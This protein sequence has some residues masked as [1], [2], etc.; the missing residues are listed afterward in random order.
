MTW[1]HI[2]LEAEELKPGKK[3]TEKKLFTLRER[4]KLALFKEM[5]DIL[6]VLLSIFSYFYIITLAFLFFGQLWREYYTI[7]FFVMALSEPY[8]GAVAVYTILKEFRKKK[9]KLGSLHKGEIFVIL[10]GLMLVI[11]LT[12]T[13]FSDN[14]VLGEPLKIIITNG[15]AVSLIYIGSVIHKP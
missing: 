1:F 7:S 9:H 11:A 4:F 6:F 8:L 15:I 10:W 13:I 5:I 14:Y 3:S 12:V 2:M